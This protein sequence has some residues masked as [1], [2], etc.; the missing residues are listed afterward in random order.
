MVTFYGT[1]PSDF[2]KAQAAYQ[3]HFAEHDPFE[4]AESVDA[5]E[6]NL[7]AAGRLVDFY[8]YPGTGHW[9]FEPDRTDAYN[10]DA[11]ALAWERTLAFLKKTL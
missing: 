3:G 6:Q 1:G 11:A 5:L 9:F 8:R 7:R 10:P 4:S 2:S